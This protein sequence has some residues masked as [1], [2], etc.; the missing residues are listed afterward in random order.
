MGMRLH[1]DT[2]E[3]MNDKIRQLLAQMTA[4][5]DELRE[6]LHEQETGMLFEIKGKRV[7]F[8]HSVK[9][10][11][12]RLK[13]RF[14]RWLVTDRPQNLVT[15]PVIYSMIVPLAVLDLFVTIY[16]A[17]CFPI[18]RIARVQRASY[19]VLDRQ[20]LEYLNFVEKFHCSYCAYASGLIA[21]VY[22]IVARTEEYFCPIKHARR[23]LGTH[24]RY[25]R[26]LDYGDAADYEARLE[27]FRSAL[28]RMK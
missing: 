17:V 8:E 13:T 16:Q 1:A 27:A 23:V 28:G 3:P 12:R 18:Y 24:S 5:E 10:A 11:H 4:L 26:F 2:G 25:P 22:E 7:E 6:A 9:Q 21:Y 14:L 19:I 15:G 20:H